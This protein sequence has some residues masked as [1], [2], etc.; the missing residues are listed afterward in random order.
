MPHERH[1]LTGHNLKLSKEQ[2][3]PYLAEFQ[4]QVRNNPIK[5]QGRVL[6]TPDLKYQGGNVQPREGKWEMGLKKMS[7]PISLSSAEWM[8]MVFDSKVVENDIEEL[9]RQFKQKGAQVG[10]NFDKPGL[11]KRITYQIG[12]LN[13]VFT[14]AKTAFPALK[15]IVCIVYQSNDL[16]REIKFVGDCLK[17]LATQCVHQKNTRRFRDV[18]YINNLLLKVNSKLGGV[19][20]ELG[21]K[22]SMPAFLTQPRIMTIGI[23]FTHPSPGK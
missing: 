21:Q 4:I 8:V 12:K 17:M 3:K 9:V 7:T 5:L 13:E 20:S 10:M 1:A 19:V 6:E 23:D 15:L 2:G 14:Q 16:Y 22:A 11:I 18:L